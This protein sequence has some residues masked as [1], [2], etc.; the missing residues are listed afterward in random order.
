MTIDFQKNLKKEQKKIKSAKQ[1]TLTN[2]LSTNKKKEIES[3]KKKPLTNSSST[4]QK[5]KLNKKSRRS[6]KLKNKTKK[7]GGALSSSPLGRKVSPIYN[8]FSNMGTESMSEPK[9]ILSSVDNYIKRINEITEFSQ[10]NILV[11]LE[12]EI[13]ASSLLSDQEKKTLRKV[14]QLKTK[15]YQSL[16]TLFKLIYNKFR[17]ISLYKKTDVIES[18]LNDL[19]NDLSRQW[20]E[21]KAEKEIISEEKKKYSDSMTT[22]DYRKTVVPI[23]EEIQKQFK[24]TH[25]IL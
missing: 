11:E 14:I 6:S 5:K 23:F 12:K 20:L 22:P 4:N 2:S 3:L 21:Y 17:S 24:K 9:L 10:L 15:D 25:D 7:K 13:K 19:S 1:K 16:Y 8:V 18:K